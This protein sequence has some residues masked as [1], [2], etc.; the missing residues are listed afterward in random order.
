MGLGRTFQIT[1]LFL[2]LTVLENVLLALEALDNTKFHLL[3]PLSSYK[4]L[5]GRAEEN[6]EKW[7]CSEKR[8]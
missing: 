6:L 2:K 7:A 4:H 3:R 8:T 5:L 1:K